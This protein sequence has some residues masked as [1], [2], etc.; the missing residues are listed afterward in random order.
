MLCNNLANCPYVNTNRSIISNELVLNDDLSEDSLI[1]EFRSVM[2][3]LGEYR[4]K[5]YSPND[6]DVVLD[7]LILRKE[8]EVII[9]PYLIID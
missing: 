6:K 4:K 9:K 5:P 1:P 8:N 7:G 2:D 3:K